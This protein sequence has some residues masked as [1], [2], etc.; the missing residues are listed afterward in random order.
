M[1]SQSLIRVLSVESNDQSKLALQEFFS[2]IPELVFA[3]HAAS[4][5]AAL[6]KLKESNI[7]VA[8]VD[9]GVPELDGVELTKQIRKSHASVRVLMFTAS[10]RPEDIFAA[11]NAG[12]D[13][14]VLKGNLSKALE[15]AI[16]SV[17]LGPVWLDPGIAKH[18]LQSIE[19][20][21][22]SSTTRVL[23]TGLMRLPLMPNEESVLSELAASNCTDGVCMVDASFLKKLRRFAPSA[24]S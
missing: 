11:M 12:A 7:D 1:S 8:L 4:A 2:K 3:A 20:A 6:D 21:T 23:Q 14:Y 18:V 22:T 24:Q 9:L 10:E 19:T 13:G 16:R 15:M 17:R 5:A